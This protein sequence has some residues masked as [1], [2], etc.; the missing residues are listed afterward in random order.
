MEIIETVPK[1]SDKKAFLQTLLCNLV[2]AIYFPCIGSARNG[3]IALFN[4]VV[5]G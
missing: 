3:I 2:R 1:S 5:Q 4:K